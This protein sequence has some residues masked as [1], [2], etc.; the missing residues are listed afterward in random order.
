MRHNDLHGQESMANVMN[1]VASGK[2]NVVPAWQP[3]AT[4]GSRFVAL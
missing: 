1:S 2:A 4:I 3:T